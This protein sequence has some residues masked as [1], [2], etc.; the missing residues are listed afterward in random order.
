MMIPGQFEGPPHVAVTVIAPV[1]RGLPSTHSRSADTSPRQPRRRELPSWL[2]VAIF[3]STLLAASWM[4][5]WLEAT[6]R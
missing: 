3:A 1:P 4:M 6:T 5:M 2:K